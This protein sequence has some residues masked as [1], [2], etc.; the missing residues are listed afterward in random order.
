MD[1]AS[2][3]CPTAADVRRAAERIAAHAVRTPL[4]ESADLNAR[5]GGRVWIKAECLQRTGSFKFRGAYNRLSALDAEQRKAGVVAW[6]SGNHAQGI[7]AA[8]GLLG[9][10]ATI[11]MPADAPQIKIAN[12]RALGGQIRFYDRRSENREEIGRELARREGAVLVPSYDDPWIIAGQ[13]TVGLEI[14]QQLSALGQRADAVLVPA[15]GGGLIAGTSLALRDQWPEL[16]VHV[17]EPA[18]FDDHRR[19]LISGQRERNPAGGES[20]CD[21]LLAPEPGELTFRINRQTLSGGYAVSDEQ[22]MHAVAY[23]VRSL[24]LVLEPSGALALA[25]LLA[26]LHDGAGRST[27]LVVSGG[28]ID[29]AMLAECLRRYPLA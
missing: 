26:G 25:A 27:V 14:A 11:V 21:A 20:I 22:A 16:D 4:L 12:T 28:N 19:S 2:P 23:A 24:K 3:L 17:V 8:A 9:M 1:D 18:G 10:R 29:P 7:A 15:S 5:C 6:S 13:G